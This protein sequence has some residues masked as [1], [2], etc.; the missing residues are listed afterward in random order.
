MS[1]CTDASRRR[2]RAFWRCTALHRRTLQHCSAPPAA[3]EASLSVPAC[4]NLQ[5]NAALYLL[6]SPWTHL[7][8]CGS[9]P[10]LHRASPLFSP[11][12]PSPSLPPAST[13]AALIDSIRSAT[14]PLIPSQPGLANRFQI[15][16]CYLLWLLI[17]TECE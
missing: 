1:S 13:P 7:K 15:L 17:S 8:T 3:A 2:T 11:H 9:P 12:L 5:V 6:W 16:C 14:M 4:I 10:L